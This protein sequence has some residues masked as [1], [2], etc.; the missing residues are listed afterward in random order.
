MDAMFF[1]DAALTDWKDSFLSMTSSILIHNFSDVSLDTTRR[2][3]REKRIR[4][5]NSPTST[6]YVDVV[7]DV[8][9]LV[10][11]FWIANEIVRNLMSCLE[12]LMN[13]FQQIGLPVKTPMNP[14]RFYREQDLYQQFADVAK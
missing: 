9:N 10:P 4:H 6:I 1:S 7:K 12:P 2:L 11:I 14:H 3:L 8:L 5:I 13:S